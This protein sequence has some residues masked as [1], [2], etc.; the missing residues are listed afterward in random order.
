MCAF[1]WR[2]SSLNSWQWFMIT[3]RL[4]TSNPICSA[5]L[6]D[7]ETKAQ[8]LSDL[9]LAMSFVNGWFRIS[10]QV[11]WCHYQLLS[12]TVGEMIY[13]FSFL[14]CVYS[15]FHNFY[16]P[17]WLNK[18]KPRVEN[19]VTQTP[20]LISTV[21]SFS[22]V[23]KAKTLKAPIATSVEWWEWVISDKL[24]W[25]LNKIIYTHIRTCA[26]SPYIIWYS[27][28]HLIGTSA[29]I[30]IT[31]RFYK[32]YSL[33]PCPQALKI[34]YFCLHQT[35]IQLVATGLLLNSELMHE[36]VLMN[37]SGGRRVYWSL[38]DWV[39]IPLHDLLCL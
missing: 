32:A 8:T 30:V 2:E 5:H 20:I 25:R 15:F 11:S 3:K 21:Q 1:F 23:S 34:H 6:I 39:Q 24:L 13:E 22:F 4:G 38:A 14:F 16:I 18:F 26:P 17:F 12:H 19:L 36:A 27:A 29:I 7:G 33:V 28:F 35:M 9:S 10:T 31:L 37:Y